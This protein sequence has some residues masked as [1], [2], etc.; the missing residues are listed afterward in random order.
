M[1]ARIFLENGQA[2]NVQCG[3]RGNIACQQ[4]LIFLDLGRRIG[5]D[6]TDLP[7]FDLLTPVMPS[8]SGTQ[9]FPAGI[10]DK[11]EVI[12]RRF[13]LV[14]VKTVSDILTGTLDKKKAAET[15]RL[16]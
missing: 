13:S 5:E 14:L 7:L 6:F 12:L 4:T 16:P 3:S 8:A 10:P 11:L 1:Q 15:P 2:D 9:V